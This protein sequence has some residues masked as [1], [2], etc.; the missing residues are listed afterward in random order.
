MR[1]WREEGEVRRRSDNGRGRERE[2]GGGRGWEGEGGEGRTK[3]VSS[4]VDKEEKTTSIVTGHLRRGRRG[5]REREEGE[6]GEV[7]EGGGGGGRGRRG[8]RGVHQQLGHLTF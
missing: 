1:G 5:R 3:R 2:E 8:G 6:E 4:L 7:G